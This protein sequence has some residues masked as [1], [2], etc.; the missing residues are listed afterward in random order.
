MHCGQL[1]Q[2]LSA[3]GGVDDGGRLLEMLIHKPSIITGEIGSDCVDKLLEAA[4][5][6]HR[7]D[8]A[9]VS[10]VEESRYFWPN[11]RAYLMQLSRK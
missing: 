11:Y 1:L 3:C 2:I 10:K 7:P 9:L 5:D 4:L 8:T 6:T